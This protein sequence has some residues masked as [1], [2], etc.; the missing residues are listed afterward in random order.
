MK[1]I[2]TTPVPENALHRVIRYVMPSGLFLKD[3]REIKFDNTVLGFHGRA[4]SNRCTIGVP[5]YVRYRLPQNRGGFRGYLSGKFYSWEEELVYL[6]AHEIRHLWQFKKSKLPREVKRIRRHAMGTRA[7][8][9]EVDASL[10]GI[11]MV[12]QYRRE[13]IKLF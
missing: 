6:L 11:R 5:E 9:I 3:I 12:R 8:L 2:N 1:L 4:W 13:G 10:Y 7:K